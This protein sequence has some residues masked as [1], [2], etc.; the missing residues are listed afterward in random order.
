MKN[1]LWCP[2]CDK[3]GFNFYDKKGV[4][5]DLTND[6]NYLWCLYC[7]YRIFSLRKDVMKK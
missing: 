1:S 3:K 4:R 6:I 7:N 2:S 5:P